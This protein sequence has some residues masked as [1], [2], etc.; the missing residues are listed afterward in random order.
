VVVVVG[1]GNGSCGGV[2]GGCDEVVVLVDVSGDGCGVV[3][4]DGGGVA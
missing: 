4:G 3:V 2:N 1:C